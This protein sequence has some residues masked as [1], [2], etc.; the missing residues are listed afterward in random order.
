MTPDRSARLWQQQ[1]RTAFK[2]LESH[3][4]FPSVPVQIH[5]RSEPVARETPVEAQVLRMEDRIKYLVAIFDV[6]GEAYLRVVDNIKRQKAF[7]VVLE[8]FVRLSWEQF[9][10]RPTGIVPYA[11]F[12]EEP[13]LGLLQ[14]RLRYWSA[15]GWR[16]LE[17]LN[18]PPD[19]PL[20]NAKPAR[21]GYRQ[22]VQ[23]W[24]ER[25]NMESQKQAARRLGVSIDIL[26]SIMSDKGRAR[27]SQENLRQVLKKIGHDEDS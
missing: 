10:A 12:P 15:E 17:S 23:S 6:H 1:V 4:D 3:P 19:E 11:G 20:E 24:M 25:S 8:E 22:E 21:R 7:M 13:N 27:Y 14:A 26:K 5:E 18:K 9:T 16:R 2:I